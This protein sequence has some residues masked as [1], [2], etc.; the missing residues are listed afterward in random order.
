MEKKE[1]DHDRSKL[2]CPEEDGGA[3]H[4]Y[5][6]LPHVSTPLEMERF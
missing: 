1:N 4:V 6:A 5:M 2:I 3:Q